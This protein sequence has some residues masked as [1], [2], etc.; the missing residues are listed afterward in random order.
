M[1][2]MMYVS[3]FLRLTHLAYG[4]DRAKIL[5]VNTAPSLVRDAWLTPLSGH[6]YLF[7]RYY[8]FTISWKIASPCALRR[9]NLLAHPV[10]AGTDMTLHAG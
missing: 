7:Q 8:P 6:I 1:L 3:Y 5:D 2:H 9:S 10:Y 4:L